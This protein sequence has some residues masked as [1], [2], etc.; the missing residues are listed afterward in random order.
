MKIP[1]ASVQIDRQARAAAIAEIAAT[2]G[3]DRV[4]VDPNEL[5]Q[6][7]DPYRHADIA[8]HRPAAVVHPRSTDEVQTVV[9]IAHAHGVPL[10]TFSQGRN[11]GY[12]G[13]APRVDGSI[14]LSLR[15]MN[16]IIEIDEE[17]AYAVVEPGVRFFDL[18]DEIRRRGLN[19]WP[20]IPDLGWGSIIGNASDHGVGFTPLGDHPGRSCG[21]EVVLADGDVM[22]T[23]YGAMEGNETWHLRKHAFGPTVEGLFL[24]SNFGIITRMGCWL[25]P[26]PETY[27]SADVRVEREEDLV[28]LIDT[29]R[30]LL[31]A[32]HIQNYPIAY[33]STLI[34][35]AFSDVPR[36]H[37]QSDARALTEASKQR[38]IDETDCGAWFMRFAIYGID[39]VVSE[40]VDI[41]RSAFDAIPGSR[42]SVRRYS[43]SDVI[44]ALTRDR[45]APPTG[46][47]GAVARLRAQSDATQA[48]IP[49]LDLLDNVS[50]DEQGA[51]GHLD[52][53]PLIALDGVAAYEQSR[54]LGGFC[55]ARGFDYAASLM[56]TPRA[57]INIMSLWLAPGDR[58]GSEAAYDLTRELITAGAERG[59]TPYRTHLTNMD[60]V[61]AT[62]DFNDGALGD[63]LQE[64][65]HA[66]DPRG[67]LSPGRAG[68][69]PRP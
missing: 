27:V 63:L 47:A 55:E 66:V 29:T 39:D 58:A 4:T 49:T 45:T 28:A 33:N 31:L 65:K 44:D 1:A 12:G 30:R 35:G 19:L 9:R 25:N 22:R 5:R 40:Q 61:A 36:E 32:G 60:A 38:M 3:H 51:G 2:I 62:Y 6:Y 14:S 23:G 10:W 46:P 54:W 52:Y 34:A 41:C 42:L 7:A 18:F 17:L 13:P 37:W 26:M 67:V 53:S 48:G 15:E 68:I 24:Q 59:Y 56:I 64:I 21:M 16:R 20:S 43:G 57:L 11:N 50:W 8:D 69:W